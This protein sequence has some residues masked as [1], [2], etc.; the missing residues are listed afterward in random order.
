MK[1]ILVPL[2]IT[3]TILHCYGQFTAADNFADV[4][5]NRF[6]NI[7]TTATLTIP[8]AFNQN[9][10]TQNQ[11]RYLVSTMRLANELKNVFAWMPQG[12][13]GDDNART[14]T[15]PGTN[16][17][18]FLIVKTS[19]IHGFT[20][21]EYP[22]TFPYNLN[23]N[24]N[25]PHAVF[26]RPNDNVARP[27]VL[28]TNG[29]T[30]NFIAEWSGSLLLAAD[31]AMRGY[32]VLVYENFLSNKY[33]SVVPAGVPLIGGIIQD[34]YPMYSAYSS[35]ENRKNAIDAL[36][37]IHLGIAAEQLVIANN[38]FLNVDLNRMYAMGGSWGG[39]S[40]LVLGYADDVVGNMN[41]NDVAFGLGAN[42]GQ[43]ATQVCGI[44]T[45]HSRTPNIT[46]GYQNRI[47][48]VVAMGANMPDMRASNP[49][50]FVGSLLD[51]GDANCPTLFLHA[52]NDVQQ[53]IL[54]TSPT[55]TNTVIS[56]GPAHN[57]LTQGFTENN[58]LFHVYVNCN[59][60][61]QH[62]WFCFYDNNAY[63]NDFRNVVTHD[64]AS[65]AAAYNNPTTNPTVNTPIYMRM[66][67]FTYYGLQALG[68]GRIIGNFLSRSTPLPGVPPLNSDVAFFIQPRS[69]DAVA[70][71]VA[72]YPQG[73]GDYFVSVPNTKIPPGEFSTF[74]AGPEPPYPG[75]II[76]PNTT[77]GGAYF[78]PNAGRYSAPES[79]IETKLF[80][81]IFYPNPTTGKINIQIPMNDAITGY[82]VSVFA[83]DGR[84]IYNTAVTENIEAG[85]SLQK[86]ID[87]SE[88][89]NGIYFIRITSDN[90]LL[91]NKSFAL[92]K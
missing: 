45:A 38:A 69:R 18:S 5:T 41:F 49:I 72:N 81:S 22:N 51:A 35:D 19:Q 10:T 74:L 52:L 76:I 85:N 8:T 89:P 26:I 84:S 4:N 11:Y 25:K 46:P 59:I 82:S 43:T 37:M 71:P 48:A 55:G 31:L 58:I 64:N 21:I 79:V 66:K 9:A 39:R 88:Q 60:Y 28:L 13:P 6:F 7:P 56:Y 50:P 2:M 23:S 44:F 15:Y 24:V 77:F 33:F 14:E 91:L 67:H 16:A 40:S 30:E 78:N 75:C 83:V 92:Q 57:N 70:T 53:N 90:K 27:C 36:S 29:W 47:R 63:N 73:V 3:V 12:M 1:K 42:S 80:S 87:I 65:I 62:P 54:Q 61:G 34:Y 20:N 86:T 17:N 32:A 68:T